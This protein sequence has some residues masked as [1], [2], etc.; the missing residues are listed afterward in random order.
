MSLLFVVL[1]AGELVA[2]IIRRGDPAEAVLVCLVHL[3]MPLRVAYHLLLFGK[4]LGF[5]HRH[6][7]MEMLTVVHVFAIVGAA[8]QAGTESSKVACVICG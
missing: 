5:T 8:L 4:H 7:T 3:L 2:T 6:C 1:A